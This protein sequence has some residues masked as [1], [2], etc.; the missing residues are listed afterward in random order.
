MALGAST[1]CSIAALASCSPSGRSSGI[2]TST[3]G[4]N[5]VSRKVATWTSG[6]VRYLISSTAV[7]RSSAPLGIATPARTGM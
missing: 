4:K 3:T 6:R 2:S 7:A 5:A 1:C